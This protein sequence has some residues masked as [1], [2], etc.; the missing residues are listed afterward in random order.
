MNKV[1]IP[2][3]GSILLLSACTGGG[4]RYNDQGFSEL[5]EAKPTSI[6]E[7]NDGDTVTLNPGFV[8]KKMNGKEFAMYSYNGQIPGPLLKVRQGSTFTVQVTNNLY[9]P[10]TIHW[11]GIRLANANDGVPDVTQKAIDPGASFTYTV[12]VP[13]EGM[14]WYHPHVREDLQQDMGLYGNLW[15]VPKDSGLYNPVNREEVVILDDLLIEGDRPTPY[16]KDEANFALMGRF[17]NT[18]LINGETTYQ[19]SVQRGSVVR[20]YLTNAA[21]TRTF[22]VR[23]A[24]ATMKRVGVDAGRNEQEEFV[25][26]ILLSP[27]ERAVVEVLFDKAETF[28]LEHRTPTK[29]VV[30]GGVIV[31]N[32]VVTPSYAGSFLTLHSNSDV[33]ADI[34]KFRSYAD[35]PVDKIIHLSVESM[36]A[37]MMQ[38]GMQYGGTAMQEESGIEWEDP[39]PHKN[40]MST[41]QNTQWKLIDESSAAENM[42]IAY[43]FKVGDKVKIRLVNDKESDPEPDAARRFRA[44]HPMQHPIHFHGQRFLVLSVNGKKN[45]NLAWKDTVLVPKDATIDILLDVTNPGDWMFHCHIAEH[46]SNGMMGIFRVK[47]S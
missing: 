12:T 30:L 23:F 17:G 14:F 44:S 43:N 36:M 2:L 21:N 32:E 42:D 25:D 46:L 35:Q 27:S 20:F 15:V 18:M 34:K 33:T 31:M 47:E 37:G 11:H 5:P 45:E 16:G 9:V 1:L 3:L 38:D 7:I 10:T 19:I 8:R 26:N 39:M 41:K 4:Y 24:G 22:N 29:V 28:S 6:M 13:D 40:S